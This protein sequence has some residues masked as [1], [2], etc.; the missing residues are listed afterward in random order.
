[1]FVAFFLFIGV[2]S[3]HVTVK[4]NVS[5]PGAWETYT[6]KIPSEKDV[7][8]IKVTLKVPKGVEFEQYQ[9][10]P[11]W[12][13]TAEKDSEGHV[14]T[15]TWAAT[16]DGIAAGEFQQFYF[17]VKNPGNEGQVG[18]DAF[19]YYQDGS[20][21]EWTGDAGSD[22]PHSVTTISKSV[23]GETSGDEEAAPKDEQTNAD[24]DN[25]TS[26]IQIA[27][28]VISILA[29]ILALAAFFRKRK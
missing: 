4:P 2:A 18:W 9:P 10:V 3:A 7:S 8:T 13:V 21:V 6:I 1:M 24:S 25:G 27:T 22:S 28:L 15:V 12:D 16:G 26:G 23:T 14:I 5:A 17:V 29:L 20:I 11:G 19:Q